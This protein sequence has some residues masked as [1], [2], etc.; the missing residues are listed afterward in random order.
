MTGAN[1]GAAQQDGDFA[2]PDVT[3][4]RQAVAGE[5]AQHDPQQPLLSA[6]GIEVGHVFQL[7]TRYSVAMNATFADADGKNRH[8]QMGSYGIGVTRLAQAVAEQLADERGLNW[9]AA[10]AP[11]AAILTVV[12]VENAA[13][14]DAAGRLYAELQAAGVEVLLDDRP[15]R[16]GAKFADADL[17][18][19]PLRVTVGRGIAAGE[20]ELNWRG[21]GEKQTVAAEAQAVLT[22]L[23]CLSSFPTPL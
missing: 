7:G 11:Y 12:D 3:D 18:G 10:L 1:W 23:G 8:F 6:R 19:I 21:S 15:L 5:A 2:L 14:M 9:P 22:A 20:I 13:Q 4:L 17:L 16:A